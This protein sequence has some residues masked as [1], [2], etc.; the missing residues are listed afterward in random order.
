M[1]VSF[2]E[3]SG[4]NIVVEGAK[5]NADCQPIIFNG[6]DLEHWNT[7]DLVGTKYSLVYYNAGLDEKF[8]I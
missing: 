8:V 4:C 7:D 3:Y 5:L 2:G 6:A 1:L